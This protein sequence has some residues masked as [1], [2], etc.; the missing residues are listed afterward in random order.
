MGGNLGVDYGSSA[1]D[2]A[3]EG[4]GPTYSRKPLPSCLSAFCATRAVSCRS[5]EGG[6]ASAL[7]LCISSASRWEASVLKGHIQRLNGKRNRPTDDSLQ[8]ANN[9]LQRSRYFHTISFQCILSVQTAARIVLS[10]M[11]VNTELVPLRTEPVSGPQYR[12]RQDGARALREQAKCDFPGPSAARPC[13]T[14]P[15]HVGCRAFFGELRLSEW[16]TS[17]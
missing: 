2:L 4:S 6:G 3:L 10:S 15:V 17:G 5:G 9:T 8:S 11:S 16:D 12:P 7:C 13:L 14:H 1:L